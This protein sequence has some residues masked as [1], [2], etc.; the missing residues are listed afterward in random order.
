MTRSSPE[1]RRHLD[2]L[3][4][5]RHGDPVRALGEV[6]RLA[7]TVGDDT[8]AIGR[9]RWIR[10]LLF[11]ELVRWDE[12]VAEY[13]SAIGWARKH[14]LAEVETRARGNLAVLLTQL[15]RS[16]EGSEQLE[17]AARVAPPEAQGV[18]VYLSALAL[19]RQGRHREAIARYN[20]AEPQLVEAGDRP[21]VGVL[22]LNRG[23]AHIYLGE[24]DQAR[25]ELAAAER[26]ADA[27]DL[28]ILAGMAAHNL[29]FLEGR[30]GYLAAALAAFD[31]AEARYRDLSVRPRQ[32]PVL[33]SDRAEV[34]LQ[35]GLAIDA[36]RSATQAIEEL[37]ADG[38]RADLDEAR[39]L[40]ARACLADGDLIEAERVAL[41]AARGF[42]VA[43]RPAW[44]LLA[45]YVGRQAQ[46][47]R[48]Q[49][50]AGGSVAAAARL[51]ARFERL[52][53][54]L[55]SQGWPVEGRDALVLAA[56]SELG[57]GDHRRAAALLARS[58]RLHGRGAVAH[59][60]RRYLA[61]ALIQRAANDPGRAARIVRRGVSDASEVLATTG[62]VEARLEALR[63]AGDLAA[64][65]AEIALDRGDP[66]AALRAVEQQRSLAS[67]MI[68]DP[69]GGAGTGDGL[70]LMADGSGPLPPPEPSRPP[71]VAGGRASTVPAG[72]TQHEQGI[73]DRSFRRP[74][75]DGTPSR[76]V[77][78]AGM[79]AEAST[80]SVVYFADV[81]GTVQAIV[82]AGRSTRLV[83]LA[84]TGDVSREIQFHHL[85]VMRAAALGP[86]V[87]RAGLAASRVDELLTGALRLRPGP[88]ALIPS[89]TVQPT[90]WGLLPSLAG[91]EVTIA[92]SGFDWVAARRRPAL[93]NGPRVLLVSGPRVASSDR[94][95]EAIARLY[96][97]ATVLAGGEATVG[98]VVAGIGRA[99]VVHIAAHGR[100][101]EDNPMFSR[102]ELADGPLT[103][104]HLERLPSVPSL[105]VLSACEG[106]A[107]RRY[108]SGGALGPASALTALGAR[109][110]LAPVRPVAD[111]MTCELMVR[112]HRHLATGATPSAALRSTVAEVVA[113]G[114][115]VAMMTAAQFVVM[116][117]GW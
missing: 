44:V 15:G 110:V 66:V 21:T 88:L 37:T 68:L 2:R 103:I 62:S 59:R 89:P 100:L 36:R 76:N 99:D 38:N 6:D 79:R 42:R 56:L 39:L 35:A 48:W 63:F 104:H 52:A 30:R 87:R 14:G 74:A 91:R 64:L 94:E 13:G 86:T 90:L 1:L 27:F 95:V 8:D 106:A 51:P 117:A 10:A 116:G 60:A 112:F 75:V 107:V 102:V 28:T 105:V 84:P 67:V 7:V 34:L 92:A 40:L 32:M 26:V 115:P 18:V 98:R 20:Q 50:T 85:E 69:S 23:V 83:T 55:G 9:L 108:R 57:G 11:H 24:T 46:L 73:R 114:D 61:G 82:V 113:D 12:A 19:Q 53:R 31:R 4:A 93:P 78:W 54:R 72:D 77:S 111:T 101:R 43:R 16:A 80:G 70:D 45:C 29:G 25:R 97:G 71:G 58:G 3:A 41:A 49:A 65:G 5:E 47:E 81:G 96:P 17:A 22:H 33:H 109:S